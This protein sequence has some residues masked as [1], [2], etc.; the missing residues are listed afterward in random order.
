MMAFFIPIFVAMPERPVVRRSFAHG[1]GA[2][3]AERGHAK[4]MA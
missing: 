4:G 2:L 1:S 3:G